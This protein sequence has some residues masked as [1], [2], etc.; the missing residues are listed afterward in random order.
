METLEPQAKNQDQ[1]IQLTTQELSKLETARK[2][3]VANEG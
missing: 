3:K 1:Q 2:S